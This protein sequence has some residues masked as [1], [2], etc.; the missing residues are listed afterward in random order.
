M[1]YH[2]QQW[3]RQGESDYQPHLLHH[4]RLYP[5]GFLLE[6]VVYRYSS[7][8]VRWGRII[9]LIYYTITV[10]IHLDFF[11]RWW[12]HDQQW[13]RQGESDYQPHLL[14]HHR[15]YP[16][17]FLL[18]VVVY[19]YQQWL[20]QGE[21]DHQL[22]YYTI[23][24]CIHLDFFWRWCTT[25]SSGCVRG[26][27]II[28][29][30]YYTITVCIHLDFF[31][32]WWWCTTTSSGCVRGSRIISL[33][34]YTITVCIHL[35]FFWRWWWCTTTSSGYVIRSQLTTRQLRRFGR[36]DFEKSVRGRGSKPSAQRPVV[37]SSGKSSGHE[38]SAPS[39]TGS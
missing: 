9:S 17:G 2:Y 30:I 26:S 23:T 33:I 29:L 14:H 27:R 4:H 15:L 3:L 37:T 6:V 13:L 28:S 39:A 31:W 10:C 24:V 8:C 11:R 19:H 22:I 16:S 38:S 18:E 20:R 21:S 32:R 1:V 7:G 36:S 34:Y 12:Y 5:S 35:D 25:T